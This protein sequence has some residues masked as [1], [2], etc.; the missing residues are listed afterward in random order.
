MLATAMAQAEVMPLGG[1]LPVAAA[2]GLDYQAYHEHKLG[3]TWAANAKIN[4][5]DNWDNQLAC[6]RGRMIDGVSGWHLPIS[7]ANEE[8]VAIGCF[9]KLTDRWHQSSC[10][11]VYD[12]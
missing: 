10:D 12:G 5:I 2:R 11:K 6:A 1:R 8:R 3:I 9:G 7:D 4:G